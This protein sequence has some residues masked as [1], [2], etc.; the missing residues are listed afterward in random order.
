MNNS[1]IKTNTKLF[2]YDKIQIR[3]TV[4]NQKPQVTTLTLKYYDEILITK[5]VIILTNLSFYHQSP[6]SELSDIFH[7]A[8]MM[9]LDDTL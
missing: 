6:V 2:S 7:L 8:P 9:A 1:E 5:V 3:N 4:K